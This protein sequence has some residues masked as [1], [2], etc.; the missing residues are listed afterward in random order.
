MSTG[1]IQLNDLDD[2]VDLWRETRLE[3]QE[4]DANL[5][6]FD[7]KNAIN[8]LLISKQIRDVFA[9]SMPLLEQSNGAMIDH[10]KRCVAFSE[11][12]RMQ[13]KQLRQFL[14][15]VFYSHP[16]VVRMNQKGQ[17]IICSLFDRY[18]KDISLIPKGYR[19]LHGEDIEPERLISD[20][21]SGMTDNFAMTEY[22]SITCA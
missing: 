9:H 20:Y 22:F 8:R 17:D 12:M 1:L 10:K 14:F 4:L 15:D 3:V 2:Q 11:R 16:F 7:L 18:R 13:N 5:S 19:L 6:S 21:I